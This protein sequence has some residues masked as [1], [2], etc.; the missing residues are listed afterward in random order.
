MTSCWKCHTS[1]HASEGESWP[2]FP[3][4][5]VA[6]MGVDEC[7]ATTNWWR[8]APRHARASSLVVYSAYSCSPPLLMCFADCAVRL[9]EKGTGATPKGTSKRIR[10]K[11]PGRGKADAADGGSSSD[12]SSVDERDAD[13][14]HAGEWVCQVCSG[15]RSEKERYSYNRWKKRK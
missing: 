6:M 11:A 14:P 7:R 2:R 15:D 12:S 5:L 3:A 8:T 9:S 4:C 13:D 10:R 1:M